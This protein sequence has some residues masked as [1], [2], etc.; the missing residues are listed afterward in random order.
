MSH[1][2]LDD[3]SGLLLDD[4]PSYLLLDDEPEPSG[5]LCWQVDAGAR[6]RAWL[7]PRWGARVGDCLDDPVLP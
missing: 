2:L 1:L 7:G 3:A 4:D 5:D 6:W